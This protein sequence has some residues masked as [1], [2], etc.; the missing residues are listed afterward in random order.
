MQTQLSFHGACYHQDH[1]GIYLVNHGIQIVDHYALE[2]DYRGS[3]QGYS[4]IVHVHWLA[5]HRRVLQ[6]QFHSFVF[7]MFSHNYSS[8]L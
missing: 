8:F 6:R 5:H 1:R 4:F 2:S 3:Y 7:Q